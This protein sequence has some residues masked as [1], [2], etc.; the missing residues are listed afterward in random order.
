[1][2][3]RNTLI[4]VLFA[5]L[6][7]P[8]AAWQ[9]VLQMEALLREGQEQAQ[10]ASAR[11]LARA[12]AATWADLPP[13]GAALYVHAAG[14]PV[15]IDGSGDDW[16]E[17]PATRSAD[18]RASLALARDAHSLYAL[19]NVV[20]PS[21]V[22]A[23]AGNPLGQDG[24]G[25]ELVLRDPYGQ[26]RW[27]L[28]NAAPGTLQVSGAGTGPVGEWQETPGG[29][30][31]ELKLPAPAPP[32]ALGIVQLD[33][34]TAGVQRIAVFGAADEPL[35]LL[36]ADAVLA[37]VLAALVPERA[38]LRVVSG[39][40]WVLARA[41]DVPAPAPGSPDAAGRWRALLYRVLLAPPVEASREFAVD[42]PRLDTSVVWQALS[43]VPASA[44]R[45]S[46]DTGTVIVAAAVPIERDGAVRGAL[47][48][49]QPGDALLVLA[50]RAVFGV[51]AASLL[52][53][54]LG[55]L[56][57]LGYSG[58]QSWRIRR[59]RNA[60]E[61]VL[62]PDGRIDPHVPL[63]QAK[64]D[65]GDLARSFARLLGE[66]GAYTEYLRTLGSKL[67]HELNTPLAIVR[68]S[69]DNLEHEA[70]SDG[71]RVYADR[72]RDGDDR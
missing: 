54:L 11:A 62:R 49:E 17:Y 67:S 58:F 7:L 69:L 22:R 45:A 6:L 61:R 70:L 21:R 40:G 57:V 2:R 20:D 25:I 28:G 13:A 31:I 48:L 3:A 52:A 23:D 64:D 29:Y 33:A 50:N 60:A 59:L 30:R 44:V 5:A 38:R 56:V 47:L 1:M 10:I 24:D 68:S 14:A 53:V 63:L 51:L 34:G 32:A 8:W 35:V 19:L 46:G 43:G 66:I 37:R 39:E 26:R 4:L 72:A 12:V 71:A 9:L 41:G 65:L 16:G 55:A 15:L 42:N 27:V 18:G 36:G